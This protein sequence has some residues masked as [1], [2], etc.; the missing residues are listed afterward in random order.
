MEVHHKIAGVIIRNK[1]LLM[2][3][4]Y[5]ELHFIMPGGK[6]EK[7]ET[8]E[9]TLK[10][11]LKEELNINLISMKFFATQ[12][13]RH[14][15]D[16]N[17]LVRMEMYFVKIEGEP[18]ATSEINEIKWIDSSYKQQGIKVASIN[19]DFTIP[20]LKKRGLID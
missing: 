12:E 18:K 2:V 17:K 5:N 3:R 10:R 9:A 16:K 7:G 14:F 20:E 6:I 1:K 15:Q 8:P 4:K 11:E 19:E 13:A